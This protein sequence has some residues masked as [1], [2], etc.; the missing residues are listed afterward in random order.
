[1]LA[2]GDEINK[3][4]GTRR[5]PRL[6][7]LAD[8]PLV[9]L[10]SSPGVVPSSRIFGLGRC[11]TRSP[12]FELGLCLMLAWELLP[13]C[14]LLQMRG[15]DSPRSGA[16]NHRGVWRALQ[17]VQTKS[18]QHPQIFSAKWHLPFTL[19]LNWIG[20]PVRIL[21]IAWLVPVVW[22]SQNNQDARTSDP[23]QN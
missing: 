7:A 15:R 13:D 8:C 11:L 4:S 12:T 17:Q 1:M 19:L 18:M 5:A 6:G 3:I 2:S 16:C 9:H 23:S 14:G 22:N 10:V 20:L 21:I